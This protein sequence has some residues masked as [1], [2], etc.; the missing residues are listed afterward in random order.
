MRVGRD[1]LAEEGVQPARRD[2]GLPA[3][4]GGLDRG[5]QL[6]HVPAGAGRDVDPR[7]PR[8]LAQLGLDLPLQVVA[9]LLVEG[10]PLVEGQDDRAARLDGHGDDPLVLDRDRLGGVDEDDGHLR[11]LDGGGGAQRGVVVGALLEVD[12]LA[13]TRGVDELPGDPAQLD[14]LVDRVAGGAGQLVDDD[15]L[16]AGHLVE[17]RGLADVGAADQGDAARAADGGAE[18]LCRGLGERLQ[19][20]VQHVAGAAAVQRG[21]GVRLPQTQRPQVG[22]VGL[23]A[24]AVDLVGAQHD[25]LA[26]LAQQ[27]YD[28][29]VGVGGADL[30]VHDEH[31]RVGGLDGVLGLRGHGRVD[32]EDVLLP[33]A[34]VDDLEAAAR[35]LGLVGD[36]VTGDTGLVLDDGLAAAD[37]PVHQGRLAD[38]GAAD[39]G[40]D[41][42]RAVPGLLD[43]ALDLLDVE[44][45]FGGQLHELRVLGVAERPV[46]VLLA[47]ALG[48]D[49]VV[50]EVRTSFIVVIGGNPCSRVIH[51]SSVTQRP[52]RRLAFSRWAVSCF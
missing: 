26:G 12:A 32:A 30:G 15:A 42:Q 44:A 31:H 38:I 19:H 8:H 11:L 29:L 41:G 10:V 21:D 25:R 13:D 4:Q 33:A 45:L 16:L 28:G 17:Q 49:V 2:P 18:G 46:V 23:A 40:E 14:Q 27:P 6:L 20:L 48:V 1:Q 22:G 52:V 9:A 24:R 47:R 36:A 39:D 34:G 43:R 35:P 5:D 50:H 51:Y 3:R 7:R 37:D